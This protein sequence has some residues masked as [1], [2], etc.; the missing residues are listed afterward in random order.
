MAFVQVSSGQTISAAH[1]NQYVNAL[2]GVTTEPIWINGQ[3]Y[4]HDPANAAS[5]YS[6]NNHNHWNAGG[7]LLS[8][9]HLMGVNFSELGFN[10]HPHIHLVKYTDSRPNT[11]ST[12]TWSGPAT[13]SPNWEQFWSDTSYPD[14]CY[15][16]VAGVY[17]L[18]GRISWAGNSTGLREL[19]LMHNG[20]LMSRQRVRP[21]SSD[22]P[23]PTTQKVMTII[24]CAYG[25]YIQLQT[26]QNTAGALSTAQTDNIADI[27]LW[28][29]WMGRS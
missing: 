25:D 1:I 20:A 12:V 5:S 10:Q 7:V 16:P 8:N 29:V 2:T 27:D 21:V 3:V 4:L 26:W 22:G 24:N 11:W 15:T 28:V 19:T 13:D 18:M 9:N 17:L 14:R 23:A 6:L